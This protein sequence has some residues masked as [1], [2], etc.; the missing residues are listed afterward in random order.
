MFKIIK[1]LKNLLILIPVSLIF[2]PFS[3][4]FTFLAY[5]NSLMLWIMRNKGSFAYSDYFSLVRDHE[6][7]YIHFD[8]VAKHLALSDKPIT[9]MEFGVANGNSYKWWLGNNTNKD[10]KFWGFDTFEG[11]PENWG[12]FYTKGDMSFTMPE[13]NDSRAKFL[14]GLFQDTLPGFIET[15]LSEMRSDCVK[16][17]HL[18]ADLYS[19]TAYV[20]AL[21]YP[22]LHKGDVIMFDEFNVPMHEYKA[23]VEF[24]GNFYV[25]L[26]PLASVN[27]FY[28]VSF[29]V[30]K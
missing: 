4:L 15:N 6:K 25:K 28:Q 19:S 14:K 5:W 7:R 21:L 22:Y 29:T 27:N 26:V 3:R 10:S 24:K 17:I 2:Q 1:L 16:V 30:D 11:L 8:F 23:F 20:L 18:D 13:M 12:P 9:Y